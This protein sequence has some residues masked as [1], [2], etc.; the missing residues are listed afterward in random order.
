[1]TPPAPH[2]TLFRRTYAFIGGLTFYHWPSLVTE[3]VSGLA[4]TAVLLAVIL[5][6]HGWVA[7][8]VLATVASGLYELRLDPN[9]FSWKD[10][11]QRE[12]GIV[13]AVAL[14]RLLGLT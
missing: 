10:C 11:A 13:L 6:L 9:G 1:M 12:V 14:A 5:L 7:L 2:P 3:F 4:L 8:F